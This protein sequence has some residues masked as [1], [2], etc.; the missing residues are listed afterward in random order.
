MVLLGRGCLPQLLVPAPWNTE[1][2]PLVV[3][4]I[5]DWLCYF[6]LHVCSS[7]HGGPRCILA[8]M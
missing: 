7:H 4:V 3:C 2:H 6:W 1:V 8:I 5:L